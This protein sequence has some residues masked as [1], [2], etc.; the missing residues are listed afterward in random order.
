MLDQLCKHSGIDINLSVK[1]DLDVDEHHTIEDT[2]I[3]LGKGFKKVLKDKIVIERNGFCLP[4]DDCLAQVAIDFGGRSWHKSSE[5]YRGRAT[6]YGVASEDHPRTL[7][8]W[9]PHVDVAC[10]TGNGRTP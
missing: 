10:G 4:M 5:H 9:R 8:R 2:A 6:R 3:A 7:C 1:G